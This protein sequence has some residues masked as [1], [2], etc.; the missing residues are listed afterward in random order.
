MGNIARQLAPQ[1]E[2]MNAQL[3]AMEAI[4]SKP[5]TKTFAPAAS[6]W[7]RMGGSVVD[8]SPE[9]KGL[10]FARAI[11]CMAKAERERLPV[12]DVIRRMEKAGMQ[13]GVNRLEATVKALGEGTASQG[14]VFSPDEFSSDFIELLRPMIAL[15][16][17]GVRTIPMSGQSLTRGRQA[18]ASVATWKGENQ[19]AT[20]SQPSFDSPQLNLKDLGIICAISNDLLRDQA[21]SADVIVR[22]DL[23]KQALLAI[24]LAG[25]R[26][27]GTAFQPKGIRYWMPAGNVTGS[28]AA[29]GT[30]TLQN[31]AYDIEVK[32]TAL[33]N[34]QNVP[35]KSRAMLLH[36]RTTGGF[37]QLRDGVGGFPIARE[38]NEHKTIFGVPFFE[39]TQIPINLSGGGS[40]GSLESEI[41]VFEAQEIEMGLGLQPTVEVSREA[42]YLDAN[43]VQQN[44]FAND[45]TV[46][47]M[48]A[49]VDWIMRHNF[50]ADVINGCTYGA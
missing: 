12:S 29:T 9:S 40:G 41:Y 23:V 15:A 14:S 22:D 6:D 36:P 21:V 7:V 30:P 31:A 32:G 50:S 18:V 26:G 4:A 43:L 24:D 42:S 37:K 38:I 45:Q 47:R 27:L 10:G 49:R 8:R 11:I 17:A 3:A 25:I 46:I 44:A 33:L 13:F 39:T 48:I 1:L 16:K 34:N 2:A 19:V 35:A 28:Q 20:Y 5:A